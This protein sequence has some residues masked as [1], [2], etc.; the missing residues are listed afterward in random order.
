M[1][2]GGVILEYEDDEWKLN[3]DP[4]EVT[5]RSLHALW[6]KEDGSKGWAVGSDGVIL[7]YETGQWRLHPGSETVTDKSLNAVSFS[8]DAKHGWAVGDDGIVLRHVEGNWL[9]DKPGWRLSPLYTRFG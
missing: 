5:D 3:S 6:L 8:D 4:G 9:I 2:D 1:G 7:T